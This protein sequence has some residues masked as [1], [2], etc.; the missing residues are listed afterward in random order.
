ML[1]AVRFFDPRISRFERA[2]PD[3]TVSGRAGPGVDEARASEVVGVRGNLADGCVRRAPEGMISEV[4]GAWG[5]GA[6]LG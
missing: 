6:S 4:G 2:Q 1:R 5:L 3:A